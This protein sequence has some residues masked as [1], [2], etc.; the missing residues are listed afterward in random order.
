M[1]IN[2]FS[3]NSNIQHIPNK[4]TL[5]TIF[6]NRLFSVF[7]FAKLKAAYYLDIQQHETKYFFFQKLDNSHSIASKFIEMSGLHISKNILLDFMFDKIKTK[8][9]LFNFVSAQ[10]LLLEGNQIQI[11]D[12]PDALRNNIKSLQVTKLRALKHLPQNIKRKIL[13]NENTDILLKKMH[14]HETQYGR[15]KWKRNTKNRLVR[16]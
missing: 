11:K 5:Y 13:K 2:T 9:Q 4:E 7:S 12:I 8:Q 3:I 14:N 10:I 1:D 15:K 16:Y 6:L